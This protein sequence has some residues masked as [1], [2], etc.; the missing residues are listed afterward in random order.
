VPLLPL[1]Y[2]CCEV[3]ALQ[4]QGLLRQLRVF[5]AAHIA[6]RLKVACDLDAAIEAF[7]QVGRQACAALVL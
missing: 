1:Q 7:H 6:W 3:A 5:D 2:L 4:H